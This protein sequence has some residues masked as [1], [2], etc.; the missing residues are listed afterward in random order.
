MYKFVATRYFFYGFIAL[1]IVFIPNLLSDNDYGN[2]EYV[3][4]LSNVLPLILLGAHSGYMH[5]YYAE[6]V[7]YF[8]SL[9]TCG[10]IVLLIS[11]LISAYL[12]AN[13]VYAFS[14]LSVGLSFILEKRLLIRNKYTLAI[15]YKPLLSV[16]LVIVVFLFKR[17]AGEY[18]SNVV[19]STAYAL[20]IGLF[21]ILIRKHLGLRNVN[22]IS[23]KSIF[24]S[25][26]NLVKKGLPLNLATI[27]FTLFVFSDRYFIKEYFQ[28]ALPSYSLSFN[29]A[30]LVVIGLSSVGLL[31]SVQIG[32]S[33]NNIVQ[34]DILKILKK[35]SVIFLILSFGGMTSLWMYNSHFSFF[36]DVIYLYLIISLLNS[37]FFIFGSVSS[38]I[39]YRGNQWRLSVAFLIVLLI[40]LGTSYLLL[41]FFNASLY[42]LLIKSLTFMFIY[43]IYGMFQLLKLL[44]D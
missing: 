23:N 20:S 36:E 44:D 10:L 4:Y 38:L 24:S 19:L 35:S 32:E 42:I 31:T 13:L 28:D 43:I 33:L 1:E 9:I 6:K 25:Y 5:K 21:F 29:F 17:I 27:V 41:E 7:D 34:G 11:G 12:S 18:N 22:F 2:L 3:K 37:S 39:F 15:L 40:S 8:K 30:Q 26:L 14:T 16:I